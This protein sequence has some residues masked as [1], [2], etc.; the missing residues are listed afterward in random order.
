MIQKIHRRKNNEISKEFTCPNHCGKAYGSYAAL[1][2][3]IKNKHPTIKPP[4]M[5]EGSFKPREHGLRLTKQENPIDQPV[6]SYDF[7][8]KMCRQIH[9][10]CYEEI[11]N[12]EL[13]RAIEVFQEQAFIKFIDTVGQLNDGDKF[14]WTRGTEEPFEYYSKQQLREL[15]SHFN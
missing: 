6:D 10:I 13:D 8:C 9:C 12:E 7:D 15:A 1:Y 3:H 14:S 11:N 4:E 5:K 2:T